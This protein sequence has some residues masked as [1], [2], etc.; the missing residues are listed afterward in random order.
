[1]ERF[2]HQ[3][4]SYSVQ[5]LSTK[6]SGT[7][8][9]PEFDDHACA[10]VDQALFLIDHMNVL[11]AL[12]HP[13]AEEVPLQTGDFLLAAFF[14]WLQFAIKYILTFFV[15]LHQDEFGQ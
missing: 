15:C 5:S 12:E 14:F 4:T 8:P 1:M 10:P 7:I 6:M 9:D 3:G 11:P 13:L 2:E